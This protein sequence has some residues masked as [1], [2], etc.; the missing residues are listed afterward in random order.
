M[1]AIFKN[2]SMNI[3]EWIEHY[4]WQGVDH[5]Y[6]IDNGSTDAY[7][8]I[9]QPYIDKNLVTIVTRTERH[10]QTE[11]YNEVFVSQKI[12]ENTT[13]LI[14]CDL[15]EFIFSEERTIREYLRGLN[16]AYACVYLEMKM[17]GSVDRYEH[18]ESIRKTFI[19]REKR[20]HGTGK[21]IVLCSKTL[22]IGIHH[23]ELQ[24]GSETLHDQNGLQLN[25]YIIQSKEYFDKV[26]KNRGDAENVSSENDRDDA[27]FYERDKREVVDTTLRDL[28]I[29]IEN[30]TNVETFVDGRRQW[31]FLTF[32]FSCLFCILILYLILTQLA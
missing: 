8:E 22:A 19:Y 21:A 17:F 4:L 16:D 20:L 3:K 29:K 1:L 14:V 30:E 25:H 24:D 10:K 18:P 5:F 9:V 15:D 26:K 2:E 27:Y 12:K 23:H 7:Q 6:M 13:W 31:R 28:V 11:H 32:L